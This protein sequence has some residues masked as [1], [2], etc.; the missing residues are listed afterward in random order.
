MLLMVFQWE[1]QSENFYHSLIKKG[2]EANG[3][4]LAF[5]AKFKADDVS[6]VT[7]SDIARSGI[8]LT[9]NNW[10]EIKP[11][12]IAWAS[13]HPKNAGE[14]RIWIKAVVVSRETTKD[15]TDITGDTSAQIGNVVSVEGK[16][17]NS[18]SEETRTPIISFE[19]L[20]IDELA[21]EAKDKSNNNTI[22]NNTI[23]LTNL[24]KEIVLYKNDWKRSE[25]NHEKL[26][27]IIPSNEIKLKTP[28]FEGI[29]H[30][31]IE[32]KSTPE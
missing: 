25:K 4:Y 5:A 31:K 10:N 23:Q 2:A 1:L 17:Y 7:I 18:R 27:E 22:I 3:S 12:I 32:K 15:L 26:S 6:E 30:G 24:S 11:K 19:A 28:L 13:L 20:D 21:V 16:V 9:E 14:T 29:I 8:I